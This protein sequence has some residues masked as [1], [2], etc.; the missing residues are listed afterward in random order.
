[1]D[2]FRPMGTGHDTEWFRRGL[3]VGFRFGDLIGGSPF[4]H[5]PYDSPMLSSCRIIAVIG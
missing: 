2:G 3:G 1:M 5:P 4:G